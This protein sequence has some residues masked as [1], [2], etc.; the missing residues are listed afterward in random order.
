MTNYYAD[1]IDVY[2]FTPF[3]LILELSSIYN[4]YGYIKM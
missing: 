2:D 3:S 4:K 1:G